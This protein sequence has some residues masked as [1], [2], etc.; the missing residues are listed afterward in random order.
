LSGRVHI[1]GRFFFSARDGSVLSAERQRQ[2][3]AV[4]RLFHFQKDSHRIAVK[5]RRLQQQERGPRGIL[6]G[7]FLVVAQHPLFD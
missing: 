6:P 4:H 1:V 3:T 2:L 5:D 7:N